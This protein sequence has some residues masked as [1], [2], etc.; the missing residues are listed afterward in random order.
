MPGLNPSSSISIKLT[1]ADFLK[2]GTMVPRPDVSYT[3]IRVDIHEAE[4]TRPPWSG[5]D[6]WSVL[7]VLPLTGLHLQEDVHCPV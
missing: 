5:Y 6:V 7:T 4:R 1:S 2:A 3:A